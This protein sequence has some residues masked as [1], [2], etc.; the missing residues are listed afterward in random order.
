LIPVHDQPP[1]A[2]GTIPGAAGAGTYL[3]TAISV[4]LRGTSKRMRFYPTLD[5]VKLYEHSSVLLI[6]PPLKF[7]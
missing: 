1:D 5:P 4:A 2:R 3:G 6:A 7:D